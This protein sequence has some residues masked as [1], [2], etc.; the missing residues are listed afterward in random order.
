[1]KL[2]GANACVDTCPAG[3]GHTDG[4]DTWATTYVYWTL[5]AT[6]QRMTKSSASY[7]DGHF[8]AGLWR[9]EFWTPGNSHNLS[10]DLIHH[11]PTLISM[12]LVCLLPY[13]VS[14]SLS[15]YVCSLYS[16][17]VISSL[18]QSI[19]PQATCLLHGNT[20]LNKDKIFRY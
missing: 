20:C 11:S 9:R 7:N 15:M 4:L 1:M 12:S 14:L 17:V 10:I 3:W 8:R 19:L 5:P 2:N 13:F 6:R 18:T 16:V